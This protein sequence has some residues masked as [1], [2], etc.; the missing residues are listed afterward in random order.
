MD[1]LVTVKH[2]KIK[3]TSNY[4][5]IIS[6]SQKFV[7]FAFN[8][9]ESW[10]GLTVFAQFIQNGIAYNQYLDSDDCCYLPAEIEEG[11]CTLMIYG[12]GNETIGTSN[13]ITLTIDPNILVANAQSTVITQSLYQ[14]LVSIVNNYT[15]STDRLQAQIDLKADLSSLTT[16]VNRATNVENN[17]QSQ[18]NTKADAS[19]VEELDTR[20]DELENGTAIAAAID[21]SV[22]AEIQRLL[23]NGAL[24]NITIEDNSITRDKVDSNFEATLAK[25][26]SAMQANVYDPL[27]YGGREVPIDPYSFAQAQDTATKNAI[28]NT[29]NYEVN[30]SAV[31]NTPSVYT[32]LN[33]ALSGVLNRAELYAGALLSNYSPINIEIVNS[34]PDTGAERTFYLVPK[35]SG[36]GYDKYWYIT[37]ETGTPKWDNFGSSST[38]VVDE[39]P[40]VGDPDTDYILTSNGSYQYFKYISNTWC[41]IAGSNYAIISLPSNVDNTDVYFA[42]GSPEDDVVYNQK[43][44][45]ADTLTMTL[46]EVVIQESGTSTG[47]GSESVMSIRYTNPTP[48]VQNPSGD[49]DYYILDD[50]NTWGHYRYF[51]NVFKQ[52]GSSAYSRSEVDSLI[53]NLVASVNTKM[54]SQDSAIA[55][56]DGKVSALG[57]MVSDVTAG[58]T[59]IVI[60]YKDGTTSPVATKDAT[61]VV[62]D[63]VRSEDG[64]TINYTDGTSDSI[65]ITGGGGGGGD[66]GGSASITRVTPS[67]TQCVYGRSCPIEY[68]FTALDSSGD[69]VGDGDATWYVGG[70]RKATSTARQGDGITN[71]FDIGE[72]L[73]VGT[74]TVRLSIAV[75]T[76]GDTLKTVTKTWTVNAINMYLTWDYEDITVNEGNTFT[77]RMTPFGDLSKVLHIVFDN[78]EE[79]EYT[80]TVTRSGVQQAITFDALEHG[81]HMVKAYLTASVNGENITSDSIYHDMIFVESGETDPIISCSLSQYTM[82]QYN[83]LQIPIVVYNPSALT[84]TVVLA[85]DGNTVATWTNV[86]RTLRYWNYTPNDYGNKSLTITCGST[87]KTLNITVEEL[88]IDNEEVGGYSFRLK[89]SDL[90]GN[91]ALRTW[92]SNGVTASFSNNFD[93]NNGGLKTETD[94]S[95]NIRQY[96]CVKAGTTMTINHKLFS[97]DPT[98]YGKTVKVIFKIENARNYDANVA[99][100]YADNIGLR[101]NAHEAIFSSTGTSVS[102]PYGEDEYIELEFDVYPA[103]T[104]NNGSFRYIMAWIDGVITTCRVYGQSDNFTQSNQNQQDIIIGS[105]DCDVYIYM[106]K[107]YPNYMTRENHIVN[108]IADA[109]NAQEMVKRYDRNDILDIS[110]EISYEKLVQQNPDCRV[111]LYD[112][113][114]MTVGKKDKVKNCSFNQ[115]WKNGDQYYEL[116]GTG[117]MTVQ[118]TSSVDY[119]LGAANTDINFTSLSDGNGVNLMANGVV[120][121][122]NYGKNYFVGNTETGEVT[123]FDVDSNTELT[124]DCIPVERDENRNVTKYIKALGYK[125]N[126]DSAPITYSN[127]KVNFASCEQVNNMCN[128]IWYQRFQPYK[129][130]TP[131]DCMEFAMGVQFI[132]DSGTV[133]DNDHFVLFGD[134]KYHMYSIANMGNSK[135][136]VHVFH[137]LSNPNECC[138]EVGNNLNDLCRMVTDDL[139]ASIWYGG[140]DKSF[141]MRYPDTDTPSQTL[142]DGW[143][144]LVSW[145][146]AN[147]PNAATGEQLSTP[148]TYGN[149]TFRGHDRGGTQVLRGSR[150]TQYAGTYTHDTFNRRMAKMLSE[151]EDYLVMDSVIYHFVYLER[152][153]M[154]DNVAKNSFWSSSDLLHW[155]LSKAYDMDTSDGNNNEGKMVFDYGNE[156]ND[157]IGSKT[158]FNANDAVWFVFASNLFEACQTMFTN[159]ETAGAWSATAYHNFLL[160]QQQKVPERVWNQCY[161]Y[162]YLRTYEREINDSWMEFLD[163][164][165]KTHQRWHY[166]YFEEIYDSSKYRG[167]SCTV[168][169][170]NFRGYYPERWAGLTNEQWNAISPQPQIHLK[171]YNKCYINV[172][173]DGTIYRQ[174]AEKGIPYTIDFS[175][176]AKL[177]DTVINIY[178]AQMIQEIGDISRLYPGTPNFSNATRLRSLTVGNSTDGYENS[179]LTGVT[180]GN[181]TML[182]Y[183]YV[184]NLAHINSGLDLSKCQSLIYLDASGSSF[185]GYEFAV[186]GLLAEAYIEAPTALSFRNLYYL[187]D[188]NLHVTDYSNL[189]TLRIE[190]CSGIDA[191][192]IID[193]ATNLARLRV[194]DVDWTLPETTILNKLLLIAGLNEN[195]NNVPVSVLTGRVYISG[196]IRNKELEDYV[197]AWANLSVSYDPNNLIAQHKVTYVNADG[198]TL[199]TTYVDQGNLP[200]EPISAGYINTPTMAS[201][202]QYNYTFS[203]WSGIAEQ[204]YAPRTVTAQYTETVRTYT[205]NFFSRPGVIHERFTEQAYGSEV[206]PTSNPTW[207]EG[208]TY[209]LFEGWDKSTGYI[210]G[211]MDVYAIWNATAYLPA[212]GTPLNEMT[213]AEIYGIASLGQQEAY[214]I[215]DGDYIDIKLGGDYDFT[216]IEHIEIG[217]DLLLTNIQRDTFVSGG[218]YFDG[219]HAFTTDIKLFDEDKSF[220]MVLDFQMDTTVGGT[221]TLVSTHEA[222]VAEGFRIYA[223]GDNIYLQWGDAT[224]IIGYRNYRTILVIRRNANDPNRLHIYT[225]DINNTQ[226][227][228]SDEVTRVPMLR[229]NATHTEEPIT[230]GGMHFSDGF[231]EYGK[232]TIHWCKIWYGD[233]G[234][235]VCNMMATFPRE[236]I[237]MEYWGAGC[238]YY[239]GLSQTCKM[240]F[241]ANSAIGGVEGRGLRMNDTGTNVGGWHDCD[242]RAWL[243]DRFYKALPMVWKSAI[244]A[245]EIKAT[246]GNQSTAIVTDYD[247]IYLASQQELSSSVLG[248]GYNQE[249]GNK[250]PI[251]WLISN[252]ERAKP[253]GRDRKYGTNK[254][255]YTCDSDPA[256]LYQS[257][258]AEGTIWV[259][260]NNNS[261]LYMFITKDEIDQYGLTPQYAADSK[262]ALG[263]WFEYKYWWLRSPNIAS[264]TIFYYVGNGGS[265]SSYNAGGTSSVVPCFSI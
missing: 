85:V 95:G 175:E 208:Q 183:L 233:L 7:K 54:N 250:Y 106:V 92:E 265:L 163:G 203:G 255:I 5:P 117:T 121:E 14:Q 236:V 169:N 161:W 74:N 37:D 189:D 124:P 38:L 123:V 33:S 79:N 186:G 104:E 94:E 190:N 144:R 9:D 55:A 215:E 132:K 206:V 108:F 27:G 86:D 83:T 13:Y 71:T 162:D 197:N 41:L 116:S 177:N 234:N 227:Y 216:N 251:S 24:A 138:V 22:Q 52:I 158:V 244:K 173:I 96:I 101:L 84:S 91:A 262:Y 205:I 50:N 21:S 179:N 90:T 232:G 114:Y 26:D 129:S 211:D 113:P 107:A 1:I 58:S 82:T 63:V 6:G 11:N 8:L 157:V 67:S 44:F 225:A 40:L 68:T 181:N 131:R 210:T 2:Q 28:K 109:P 118:G 235:A 60:H 53:A 240:S 249:V 69:M 219:S 29:E 239:A 47:E 31:T 146:C 23:E 126:D 220:T 176:Q 135:K 168:Q 78:D 99:T 188:E 100:C 36:T 217:K 72:Y 34:L 247:K 15:L 89:A 65:E 127:T 192:V 152:H 194:L 252:V 77:L 253:R 170:V 228:F 221:Q 156:A 254:T 246:A 3:V 4:K 191:L 10:S 133:P 97:D 147:N 30:D 259:N 245:V 248:N 87:V 46:Y 201:T 164:G 130:L 213:P 165:Q 102:V 120:D 105:N 207:D 75:D 141:E 142:I 66:T 154:C 155:D 122:D 32:G 200:P 202:A 212:L 182:E 214:G 98:L 193:E 103:P 145:M 160:E 136:N 171:M 139:S 231:R 45:Y 62:E 70:V 19:A 93:W 238:Y 222:G 115:F 199:Y 174:K 258:M 256:A 153:T 76:G 73:S 20:I 237:R 260:T 150:V 209:R 223:N 112:I 143:Q 229:S 17:L 204:V 25:A 59:G 167:T 125:I 148:E 184:Q 18:I 64:I 178:S 166:E 195:G 134:N 43:I 172:S 264:S 226:A 185:T 42:E 218:Y 187:E 110:G 119:L 80:M 263:G 81:S 49:K 196:S 224:Q 151:C 242:M 137:D 149:Y 12:T 111:W 51:T 140:K 57:N 257:D 56:V 243:N 198:T 88:D 61:T 159:R 230:F 16:E 35:E 128:A 48:L 39:L 261:R 241:I 180:L